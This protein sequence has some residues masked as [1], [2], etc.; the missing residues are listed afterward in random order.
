MVLYN[1]PAQIEVNSESAQV[2]YELFRR[3]DESRI[4]EWCVRSIK[5][6]ESVVNHEISFRNERKFRDVID[7]N[8][9]EFFQHYLTEHPEPSVLT[10]RDAEFFC[11]DMYVKNIQVTALRRRGDFQFCILN[12]CD[13]RGLLMTNIQ[14]SS[15]VRGIY[16]LRDTFI[17][18]MIGEVLLPL[19]NY[20]SLP[21][22]AKFDAD[23]EQ[24]FRDLM[25]DLRTDNGKISACIEYLVDHMNKSPSN[26]RGHEGDQSSHR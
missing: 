16:E 12:I 2:T 17:S 10:A 22:D 26:F 1:S 19:L 21:A 20:S 4:G 23:S 14:E 18:N 9:F 15:F 7:D 24:K 3:C 13:H 6:T 25:D 5:Y 11:G 8:L